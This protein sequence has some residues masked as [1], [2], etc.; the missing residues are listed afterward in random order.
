MLFPL[1]LSPRVIC[2]P[3]FLTFKAIFVVI[4]M[5]FFHSLPCPAINLTVII[6][7]DLQDSSILQFFFFPFH[8]FALKI[9]F[10]FLFGLQFLLLFI[11]QH[12]LQFFQPLRFSVYH[13]LRILN[14]RLNH[15][16]LNQTT[17]LLI[18]LFH[19]KIILTLH[20]LDLH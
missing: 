2:L 1:H 12:S 19:L 14:S 13:P 8:V 15:L 20:L 4:P 6:F 7:L 16:H 3:F 5:H 18:F 11:N 17:I 9:L 10:H